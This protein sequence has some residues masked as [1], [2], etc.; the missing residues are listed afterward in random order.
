MLLVWNLADILHEWHDVQAMAVAGWMVSTQ[1]NAFL[2]LFRN[3][4]LHIGCYP[5]GCDRRLATPVALMAAKRTA[6]DA[7]VMQNMPPS[8]FGLGHP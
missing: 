8:A 2:L 6:Q 1:H 3:R 7:G 4:S 5:A